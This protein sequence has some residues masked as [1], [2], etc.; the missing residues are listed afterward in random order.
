MAA[1]AWGRL[2]LRAQEPALRGP[3]LGQ[4]RVQVQELRVPL[5]ARPAPPA[6]MCQRSCRLYV[7]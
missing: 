2:Q 5:C 3:G 4:A 6:P 7:N 1:A